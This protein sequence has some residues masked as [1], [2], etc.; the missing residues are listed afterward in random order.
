[1]PLAAL[2]LKRRLQNV[3]DYQP[4]HREYNATPAKVPFNSSTERKVGG[5]DEKSVGTYN[6]GPG[7]YEY[8][9]GFDAIKK[10][11]DSLMHAILQRL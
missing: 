2:D 6:P 7:I 4:A 3:K 1:M 5:G 8:D 11:K 10:K 9:V